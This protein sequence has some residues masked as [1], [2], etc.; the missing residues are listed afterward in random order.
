M[1]STKSKWIIG[2]TIAGICLFGSAAVMAG[3]PGD[4]DTCKET[5]IVPK[6][7]ISNK[8]FNE[9]MTVKKDVAAGRLPKEKGEEAD[10][11]L[12]EHFEELQQYKEAAGC[13][14]P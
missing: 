1:Y 6:S 9:L 3:G 14:E 4:E 12:R 8:R 7:N 11:I 10:R 13:K 5:Q 2:V